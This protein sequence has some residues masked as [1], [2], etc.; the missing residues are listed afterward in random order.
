MTLLLPSSSKIGLAGCNG[1]TAGKSDIL[2]T[3]KE[4]KDGMA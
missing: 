3:N 1:E 4:E 2:K